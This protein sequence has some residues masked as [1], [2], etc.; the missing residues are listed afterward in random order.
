VALENTGGVCR[1]LVRRL[2]EKRFLRRPSVEGK[3]ILKYMRL[4]GLK[5]G[6]IRGLL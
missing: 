5:T 6:T 4:V 1:V 2:E 3:I